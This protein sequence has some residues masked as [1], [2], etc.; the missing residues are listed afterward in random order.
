MGDLRLDD[1]SSS[2][3]GVATDLRREVGTAMPS[4]RRPCTLVGLMAAA[5][6]MAA[7]I[8]AALWHHDLQRREIEQ[9]ARIAEDLA[10][11][12]AAQNQVLAQQLEAA[13]A[14]ARALHDEL[15]GRGDGDELPPTIYWQ[16]GYWQTGPGPG[17]VPR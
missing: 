15:L 3:H 8:D 14:H 6:L 12:L 10:A 7:G 11:R 16:N 2:S 1:G 5:L 9:R 4:E 17:E 13:L